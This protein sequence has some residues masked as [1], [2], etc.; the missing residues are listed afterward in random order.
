MASEIVKQGDLVRVISS[1]RPESQRFVGT[2]GRVGPVDE[3][4]VFEVR[5]TRFDAI[6]ANG[7]MVLICG[8]SK[9]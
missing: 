9:Q 8:V 2:I 7:E 3:R 4:G 1:P 6:Y 5:V